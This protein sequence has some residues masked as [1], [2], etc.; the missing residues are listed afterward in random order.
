MSLSDAEIERAASVLRGGGLVAFPTETV[1]GLGADAT[2]PRA[3]RRIFEAKGRPTSHPLI[4]HVARAE[5]LVELAAHVPH[6]A[7]VLAERFWP[8]PLTLI[9]ER[10]PRVHPGVTGGQPTVAIRVPAH[11]VALALLDAFGAPVAAPSANRFGAVSPTTAEHVRRDLGARVDLVLEGGPA[12]VGLEST[13]VDV[14]SD[15]PRVLRP[16]GI[17]NEAVAAALQLPPEALGLGG[18]AVRAPG[19]LPSHYAPRARL[20][21]TT[22]GE[23]AA[24]MEELGRTR[25]RVGVF[26]PR[27]AQ[28]PEGSAPVPAAFVPAPTEP[29]AYARALYASL[30]ELDEGADVI[31]VVPPEE[32]GIGVA[33]L[34]RLRRAAA[35]RV[36]GAD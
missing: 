19:M 8:G 6:A 11:P 29:E 26:A 2:N 3:V 10:G 21:L 16:G 12:E 27:T 32:R 5:A 33:V 34:D 7:T 1:Y 4:V 23:L 14:T 13:I 17:P 28:L 36:T 24:R 15:P 25:V 18:S 35:P 22:A 20:E 30:R 9:V 31:L